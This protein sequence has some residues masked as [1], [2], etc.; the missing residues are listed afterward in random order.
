MFCWWLLWDLNVILF[1]TFLWWLLVLTTLFYWWYCA[2][3][4]SYSYCIDMMTVLWIDIDHYRWYWVILVRLLL[5]YWYIINALSVLCLP[6]WLLFYGST[7]WYL[8][9]TVLDNDDD[10]DTWYYRVRMVLFDMWNDNSMMTM[11]IIDTFIG[12]VTLYD[13][14]TLLLCSPLSHYDTDTFPLLLCIDV[15]VLPLLMLWYCDDMYWWWWMA[16]DNGMMI[17]IIEVILGRVP[18]LMKCCLSGVLRYWSYLFWW[19]YDAVDAGNDGETVSRKLM[20]CCLCPWYLLFWW[21][22]DVLLWLT[23]RNVID[24]DRHWNY[25][26]YAGNLLL[27]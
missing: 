16:I 7:W 17:V 21:F 4:C 22:A 6:E 10:D 23:G 27:T 5:W 1:V 2:L 9:W 25:S 13:I 8:M 15:D 20:R 3:Y 12:R 19:K 24:D 26:E 14:A 18:C 11:S